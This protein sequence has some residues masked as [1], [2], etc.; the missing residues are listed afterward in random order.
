M[1]E[2]RTQ[3]SP[4]SIA[5]VLS[6]DKFKAIELC[7]RQ[8]CSVSVSPTASLWMSYIDMVFLLVRF[9]RATRELNGICICSVFVK[10]CR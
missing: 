9:V 5:S 10:S 3:L 7:Y 2:V 4:T 8:F 6:N 1:N